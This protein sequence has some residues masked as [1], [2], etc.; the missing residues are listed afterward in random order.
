MTTFSLTARLNLEG[1]FNVRQVTQRLQ[2]SLQGLNTSINIS[3][4]PAVNRRLS[5][6]NSSLQNIETRLRNISTLSSSASSNLRNL[7]GTL[8]ATATGTARQARAQANANAVIASTARGAAEAA[9]E[10]QEF[11]RVSGLAIRRFAGFTIATGIIFGFIGAVRQATTAAISFEREL[12]KVS[13]VS[14]LSSRALKG[15]TDEITA[16]STRFGVSSAEILTASRTLTQAG[17][18]VNE[19]RKSLEAIA[20]TDLAP[21]FDNIT[22]TTEGAIAVLRQFSLEAQDLES[23]LGSI[24]RVAGQ[25]AVESGDIIAAIRRTGGV[26]AAAAG[27]EADAKRTV[28]EFIA[29]FTSV[30]ATTRETAESIATGLRTIFSRLQRRGTLRAL[31]NLGIQLTTLEGKFI[32][33]FNAI[34]KLNAELKALDA[35]DV[36]FAA[37]VEE[38]GGIRQ[39]GKIIP[40]IQQFDEV[41]VEAFKEAR[42]G[43]D[44]LNTDSEVALNS[45][46]VRFERVRE[47]FLAFLRDISETQ[48]FKNLTNSLLTLANGLISVGESFEPI[49]PILTTFASFKLGTTLPRFARGFNVGI[50]SGGDQQ[51][52]Q[53]TTAQTAATRQAV[54]ATEN[55][56]RTVAQNTEVQRRDSVG[57]RGLSANIVRLTSSLSSNTSALGNLATAIRTLSGAIG[58]S[59]LA[60][61]SNLTRPARRASGGTVRRLASGGPVLRRISGGNIPEIRRQLRSSSTTGAGIGAFQGSSTISLSSK[62]QAIGSVSKSSAPGAGNLFGGLFL[63]P[64]DIRQ[65]TTGILSGAEITRKVGDSRKRNDVPFS[66]EL[67]GLPTPTSQRLEDII[68][69]NVTRAIQDGGAEVAR[70]IGFDDKAPID[71]AFLKRFNIDNIVGNMFEAILLKGGAPFDPGATDLTANKT[72]DFPKGIGN[73]SKLFNSPDLIAAPSDAKSSLNQ[74]TVRSLIKKV[75]DTKVAAIQAGLARDPVTPGAVAGGKQLPFLAALGQGVKG[76]IPLSNIVPGQQRIIKKAISDKDFAR[77]LK[78]DELREVGLDDFI[79]ETNK[80]SLSPD[81]QKKAFAQFLDKKIATDLQAGGS[82]FGVNTLLTPG[83]LVFNPDTVRQ[84]GLMNLERFNQTGDPSSLGGFN[85]RGVKTVPGVGNTDSFNTMLPEGSFVI[86]KDS[87]AELAD[88]FDLLRRQ[89]FNSGGAVKFGGGGSLRK[90]R[91]FQ[92]GGL[93]STE[94]AEARRILRQLPLTAREFKDAFVEASRVIQTGTADAKRAADI[95]L[96]QSSQRASQRTRAEFITRTQ[97]SAATTD[98]LLLGTGIN[99]AQL[100][101]QRQRDLADSLVTQRENE[102]AAARVSPGL[103]IL[104]GIT[105]EDRVAARFRSRFGR[106][107][108]E[109]RFRNLR[110]G[111]RR[112]TP[113]FTGIARGGLSPTALAIGAF[114]AGPL[115][116]Q[117]IGNETV[118]AAGFSGGIGGAT[119]GGFTGA[120]IGSLAGLGP[121]GGV[122]GAFVGAVSGY[123]NAV[124]SKTQ[125]LQQ[126][127]IEKAVNKFTKELETF[128]A[129]SVPLSRLSSSVLDL[130]KKVRESVFFEASGRNDRGITPLLFTSGGGRRGAFNAGDQG[131]TRSL[132]ANGGFTSFLQGATVG[133]SETERR[134]EREAEAQRIQALAT[135]SS[136]AARSLI[137]EGLRSGRLS[138]ETIRTDERLLAQLGLGTDA[139]ARGTAFNDSANARIAQV[140]AGFEEV[141]GT[142]G[143]LQAVEA[144]KEREE[145]LR[146]VAA[147]SALLSKTVS[148]LG[149]RLT[150]TAN[151]AQLAAESGDVFRDQITSLNTA[152][153]SVQQI[154]IPNISRELNFLTDRQFAQRTQAFSNFGGAGA[155]EVNRVLQ[156][157]RTLRSTGFR[158]VVQSAASGGISGSSSAEVFSRLVSGTPELQNLTGPVQAAFVGAIDKVITGGRQGGIVDLAKV[159]EQEFDRIFDIVTTGIG[160]K[161]L[162][163]GDALSQAIQT[164][165]NEFLKNSDLLLKNQLQAAKI[166]QQINDLTVQ[167]NRRLQQLVSGQDIT[168]RQAITDFGA[169]VRSRTRAG[170]IGN[171]VSPAIIRQAIQAAQNRERGLRERRGAL[172]AG[173]ADAAAVQRLT[174]QINNNAEQGKALEEA[175]N[176]LATDV[177][178]LTVVENRL[179]QL[180]EQESRGRDT[181]E[182]LAVTGTGDAQGRAN[183]NRQIA[184]ALAIQS[185]IPVG[186]QALQDGASFLRELAATQGQEA[187]ERVENLLEARFRQSLISGGAS[188]EQAN[189]IAKFLVD[190]TDERTE[191]IR[192]FEF[193]NTQQ[194]A[195]L[196]EQ[197]KLTEVTAATI[198]ETNQALFNSQRQ[199]FEIFSR[200]IAR[201]FADT[202]SKPLA[203]ALQEIRGPGGRTGGFVRGPFAGNMVDNIPA[204]LQAGEFV[205]R[206][207]VARQPGVASLLTQLNSGRLS[208]F[209]RGGFAGRILAPNLVG[210]EIPI[211]ELIL[212]QLSQNRGEP[213]FSVIDGGPVAQQLTDRQRQARDAQLLR[214]DLNALGFGAASSQFNPRRS[215]FNNRVLPRGQ[216]GNAAIRRQQAGGAPIAPV[217]ADNGGINNNAAGAIQEFSSAIQRL[218]N[219]A[220]VAN[221]LTRA[222]DKLAALDGDIKI[223][224]ETAPIQ[225]NV[226]INGAEAFNDMKG[227]FEKLAVHKVHEAI[228]GTFNTITGE[229]FPRFGERLS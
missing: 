104:T 56:T 162:K 151:A 88:N 204:R 62:G 161:A 149:I 52:T 1:P 79:K 22:T 65:S 209:Q 183:L 131:L 111:I 7:G 76:K 112:R 178:A 15:L 99:A 208:G 95:G 100:G 17:F 75:R 97:R 34:G 101:S 160:E 78:S 229:T 173:G 58:S 154:R 155:N 27:T 150:E 172:L 102:R 186:G 139:G 55:N 25:F 175:L 72:F 24:N 145:T 124:I 134:Q 191:L 74:E 143:I 158:A 23:V 21:T 207:K 185:G 9:T 105:R 135:S 130:D 38:L 43:V 66:L 147:A 166:Q 51:P 168:S 200:D 142:E 219:L 10:I 29:L 30:R 144:E 171:V 197:K 195:A 141:F 163:A 90:R 93:I 122:L 176:L 192:Q 60:T 190:R 37:I 98:A 103:P 20:K 14:G 46:A 33:P 193:L 39:I 213:L 228:S 170:G 68:L 73:L 194:Q 4:D 136:E 221:Q 222:A 110:R 109:R 157:V 153:T 28:N 107:P 225:V 196:A 127:N 54:Q 77:R 113:R 164:T 80:G 133:F 108:R 53:V 32:G 19:V 11:G 214:Q 125:D 8:A 174:D 70:Q 120:T 227:E 64:E 47:R 177:S 92:D 96:R 26:F 203:A 40:L 106:D 220:N 198:K 5:Q 115:L 201:Q 202:V 61:N 182:R 82:P 91:R 212:R 223:T 179:A 3:V 189:Q 42:K 71:T 94:L 132:I 181:L 121:V 216:R 36:R 2:R 114:T 81:D 224:V 87:A 13:Q 217:N 12:V 165:A 211:E 63:R 140:V 199:Q 215:R 169:R 167:R 69:G 148:N 6:L 159:T 129:G 18:S 184:A 16:L 116:Q 83:E 152:F 45:V 48:T 218:G 137:T 85:P 128:S 180:N 44:S 118:E 187:A 59:R 188:P 138:A 146:R 119:A 210:P 206:R 126:A 226:V 117:S 50:S 89:R 35:N 49:L 41:A 86:R 31:E 123:T 84:A 156:D 57:E 205:V 67:R